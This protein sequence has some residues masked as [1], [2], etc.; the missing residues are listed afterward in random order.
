V[1]GRT[2]VVRY[3]HE[4]AGAALD[5]LRAGRFQGAAVVEVGEPDP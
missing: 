3:P 1:P 2:N 5:D 4:A